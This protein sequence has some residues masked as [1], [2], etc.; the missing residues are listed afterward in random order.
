MRPGIVMLHGLRGARGV[1]V[2]EE[3]RRLLPDAVI[4]VLVGEHHAPDARAYMAAGADCYV[5]RSQ[6]A[7]LPAIIATATAMAQDRDR[8]AVRKRRRAAKRDDDPSGVVH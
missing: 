7:D 6:A 2:V 1:R 4:V 5:D 3:F 8:A